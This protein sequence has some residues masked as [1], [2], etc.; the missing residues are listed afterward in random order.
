MT[1]NCNDCGRKARVSQYKTDGI[2]RPC[3][4]VRLLHPRLLVFR[5][6]KCR[7]RLESFSSRSKRA[8]RLTSHGDMCRAC[9]EKLRASA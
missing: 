2:C 7:C 1:I 3:T 6:I 8:Q 4:K 9:W 5:C